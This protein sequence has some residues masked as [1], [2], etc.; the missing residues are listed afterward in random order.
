MPHGLMS[1][2]EPSAMT[3]VGNMASVGMGWC[4]TNHIAVRGQ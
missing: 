4:A 2:I 1:L 3:A